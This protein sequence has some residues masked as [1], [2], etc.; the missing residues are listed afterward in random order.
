MFEAISEINTVTTS[1]VKS[2]N[3][4][5]GLATII[6]NDV[7]NLK[8]VNWVIPADLLVIKNVKISPNIEAPQIPSFENPLTSITWPSF[9][10][11]TDLC[12]V[13]F[14]IFGTLLKALM[15]AV[16]T[17]ITAAINSMVDIV[18]KTIKMFLVIVET[19]K[20]VKDWLNNLISTIWDKIKNTYKEWSNKLNDLKKKIKKMWENGE[21][22]SKEKIEK[23]LWERAIS[24]LSNKITEIGDLIA[25]LKTKVND[26]IDKIEELSETLYDDLMDLIDDI[27]L[28]PADINCLTKASTLVVA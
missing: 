17:I 11:S 10:I 7:N 23:S 9:T 15:T 18:N 1:V 5:A 12:H 19:L 14:S 21:D 20:K 16:S 25:T 2:I 13:D 3:D 27:T 22:S 8:N 24:W 26:F 6:T 4:V 28:L